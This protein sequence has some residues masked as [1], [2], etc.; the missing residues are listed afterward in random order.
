MD[1]ANNIEKNNNYNADVN[2][3]K[4]KENIKRV[5]ELVRE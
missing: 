1:N 2:S 5:K 3:P 4:A